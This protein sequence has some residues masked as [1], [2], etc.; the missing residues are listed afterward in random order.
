MELMVYWHVSQSINGERHLQLRRPRLHRYTARPGHA[1]QYCLH[2]AHGPPV[3]AASFN[4]EGESNEEE[5]HNREMLAD[6]EK[7]IMI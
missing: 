7:L 3:P 5:E 6:E 4:S 2:A 1:A